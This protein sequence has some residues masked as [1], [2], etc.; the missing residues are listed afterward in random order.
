MTGTSV[1]ILPIARIDDI[2]LGSVNNKI[3]NN[4]NNMYNK[5]INEYV[6]KN[7]YLWK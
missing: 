6:E 3:I 1:N 7:K 4:L 5:L 2:S